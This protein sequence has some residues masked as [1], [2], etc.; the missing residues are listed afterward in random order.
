MVHSE[1]SIPILLFV[2]V[3]I[4]L[5]V[6][7][8][9]GSIPFGLLLTKLAGFGDIRAIGSGN[10]GATNVLRT[11][12]KGLAALT[13]LLDGGKGAAA[14]CTTAYAVIPGVESVLRI[15]FNPS[16]IVMV[17]CVA[18]F[19]A[20]LGHVFPLWLRFKGGKG[21][22]TAIGVFTALSWP[23]GIACMV[24]WLLVAAASRISSLAALVAM[25]LAPLYAH[26]WADDEV[27]V[28]AAVVALLVILKHH[29]N[30]RR[31]LKG[32]EPRIG[33]PA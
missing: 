26:L 10:I 6:G 5:L 25:A 32:E 29:A 19:G 21:V 33:R 20:V 30:I 17:S 13:L 2:F 12:K 22:A 15:T 3:L 16:D 18:G 27:I 23:V 31:L 4:P 7:Y 14:V 24:T 28:L 8:F 11:G 9:F 1:W